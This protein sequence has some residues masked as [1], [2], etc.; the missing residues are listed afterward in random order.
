MSPLSITEALIR[1]HST[2]ESFA[3]GQTYDHER[4]VGALVRRGN[5][6][7]AEVA[8]SEPEAYS[9]TL[10]FGE[11]GAVEAQCTCPYDW[12][13]WCKHIVATLLSALHNPAAIEERTPLPDLLAPLDRDT[14]Q[15]LL[16]RLVERDPS[17]VDRV[18]AQ[19]SLLASPATLTGSTPT[20]TPVSP[21]AELVTVAAVRRALR[22]AFRGMG[23]GRDYDRYWSV[24]SVSGEVDQVLQS[25][26]HLIRTGAGRSALPVLEAITEEVWSHYEEWDD[27]DGEGVPLFEGI[28]AAWCEALLSPDVTREE[29]QRW[30]TKLA[31]WRDELAD[32]G[33]EE[34]FA[35]AVQAAKQ[36]WDSPPLLRVLQGQDTRERLWGDAD[37]AERPPDW[38][39]D[40]ALARARLNVLERAGR[41]D[42]YLRFADAAGQVVAY[43]AMLVRRGDVP[44]AVAYARENVATTD[45]ALTLAQALREYQEPWRA[46]EIA[47]HGLG[48][49][50]AKAMLATWTA[51]LAA[52]LG[53]T[54]RALAAAEIGMREA[55]T[56]DGYQQVQALAGA[57]WPTHRTALL[58]HLRRLSAYYAYLSGPVEIFLHEGLIADAMAVVDCAAAHPLRETV[59]DAA[60][61]THPDW[62]ITTSRREAEAIM[63]QGK[64]AYYG[65]A[66]RWVARAR[67]AWRVA[68]READWHT[69]LQQLLTKH[70]RKYRLVPL[71][72]ALER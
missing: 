2:P 61:P 29:R 51:A 69:Y 4:A 45:E 68:G 41:W 24:G 64:S 27:S 43:A 33:L 12:G 67:D 35:A 28:G 50:G 7:Q 53:E 66:A 63:N 58:A 22:S 26:W 13:G 44:E 16:L 70:S 3:R 21:P 30:G 38:I 47:E 62:V 39:D 31:G 5:V 46:L 65:T 15:S 52:A 17:L 34:G 55:P 59:A 42:E 19:V 6:V 72:K 10:V 14:L 20:A 40:A 9:V 8:G 54:K 56:L 11:R 49:Q 32:Y 48:L 57:D 1:Q 71:L 37:D 23:R 60:L 25:A 18:E 36:G